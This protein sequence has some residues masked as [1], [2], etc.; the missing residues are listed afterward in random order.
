[1][2]PQQLTDHTDFQTPPE[3]CKYMVSLIPEGVISVL[4]PT[5]GVGNIVSELNRGGIK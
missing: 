1:M 4:E 3:V 2:T 5:P